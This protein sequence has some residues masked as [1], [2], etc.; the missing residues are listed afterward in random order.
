MGTNQQ[1]FS[2]HHAQIHSEITDIA[3][4][5]YLGMLRDHIAADLVE[6]LVAQHRFRCF[7]YWTEE[8]IGGIF[9]HV[10]MASAG[11]SASERR[12]VGGREGGHATGNNEEKCGASHGRRSRNDATA[13][14]SRSLA[15]SSLY[16]GYGAPN[17][18]R[19]CQKLSFG[20]ATQ[21]EIT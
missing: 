21:N 10:D 3:G 15:L 4:E 17:R 5:L 7:H 16:V 9:A 1:P 12:R 8:S 2:H 19:K 13:M 11:A 14:E 20:T 6:C 18:R